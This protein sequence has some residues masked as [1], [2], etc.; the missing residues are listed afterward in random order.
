MAKFLLLKDYE[1]VTHGRE[2]NR[3]FRKIAAVDIAPKQ[4]GADADGADGNET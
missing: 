2:S 1:H 3:N 4:A